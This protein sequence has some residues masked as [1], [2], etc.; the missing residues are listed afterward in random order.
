VKTVS[1]LTLGLICSLGCGGGESIPTE[2]AVE[3]PA[4][5]VESTPEHLERPFTA[6][7]IRDEWV[8]GLE[9]AIRRWSPETEAFELW[10]VVRADAEGVDIESVA[11]DS[12]GVA[13]GAPSVQHSGW[14]E[15]R[16]HATFSS[17]TSSR[18]LVRRPTPLGELEGWLYTV[19]DPSSGTRTEFFFATSLAGAPV[20]V[21]VL[22]DGEVVEIFEQVERR[23]P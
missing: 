2:E 4:P 19:D 8:V 17:D 7:Q 13:T 18:E 10:R 15:L 6:E 3:P 9:I 11:V 21:H 1:A 22:R 14:V 16:N 5:E 20:W 23:K 12:D